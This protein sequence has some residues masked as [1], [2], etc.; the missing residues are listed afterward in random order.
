VNFDNSGLGILSDAVGCYII[1]E[2]NG[3]YSLELEYS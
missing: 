3:D 2:L 1:K